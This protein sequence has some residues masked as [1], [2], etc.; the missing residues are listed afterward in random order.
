MKLAVV[1]VL[2]SFFDMFFF[3]FRYL[4]SAGLVMKDCKP[5]LLGVLPQPMFF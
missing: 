1:V 2:I 3:K 4:Q 5:V